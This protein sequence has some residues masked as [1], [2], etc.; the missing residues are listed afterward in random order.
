MECS[1]QMTRRILSEE[2]HL[3][4]FISGKWHCCLVDCMFNACYASLSVSKR[5]FDAWK[6]VFACPCASIQGLS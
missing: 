2:D 1:A 6:I 4:F 5:S 3:L